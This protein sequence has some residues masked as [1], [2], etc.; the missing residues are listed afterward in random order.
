MVILIWRK[1]FTGIR[2]VMVLVFIYSLDVRLHEIGLWGSFVQYTGCIPNQTLSSRKLS[3]ERQRTT[4]YSEI[5]K[6]QLLSLARYE[7]RRQMESRYARIVEI[8]ITC[9]DEG[10]QD[11][12][13][14]E[15]GVLVA[16]RYIESVS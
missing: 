3:M 11:E 4:T 1:I 15:H 14:D 13:Y 9:L 10:N 2:N 5:I 7:L 12:F 8:C 6:D 16:V